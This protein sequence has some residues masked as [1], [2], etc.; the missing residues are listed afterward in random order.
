VRGEAREKVRL[1]SQVFS[2][3]NLESAEP[4]R[5]EEQL[6]RALASLWSMR[7]WARLDE[8][9]DRVIERN[10]VD[11]LRLMLMRLLHSDAPLRKRFDEF[12]RGVKWLGPAAATEIMAFVRPDRYCLWNSVA[13]GAL[14][15]MGLADRV[16]ERAVKRPL[17]LRGAE[18]EEILSFMRELR[19]ALSAELGR[20][21]TFLD[22]DYLLYYVGRFAAEAPAARRE[23]APAPPPRFPAEPTPREHAEIQLKLIRIGELLGYSTHVA[24]NDRGRVVG[25]VRLGDLASLREVPSFGSPSAVREAELVDVLWFSPD[26]ERLRYAFEVVRTTDVEKALSRLTELGDYA[27]AV[28]VVGPEERRGEFERTLEKRHI[29]RFLAGKARYMTY[30][31]VDSLLEWAERYREIWRRLGIEPAW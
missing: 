29:R 1:F 13:A 20:P 28:F 5:L 14:E 7:I 25:R 15:K 6:R 18:Y 9:V 11:R 31:E 16:P 26:G 8:A 17:S 22:L 19:E 30:G 24:R 12:V 3:E 10:G 21:A 23:E 2:R 27:R 4:G